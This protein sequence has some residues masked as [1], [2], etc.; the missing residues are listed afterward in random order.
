MSLSLTLEHVSAGYGET[1]VLEDLSLS[2]EAGALV[3]ILGR[4]GVGKT[5][6]FRTLMGHTDLHKGELLLNTSRLAS[7]SAHARSRAGLGWVPQDRQIFPSLTVEENIQIA[8]RPGKWTP[9]KVL[10]LFPQIAARRDNLGAQLSGGEQQMLSLARALVGN[11]SVLLLDEP[12]EGL[13]PTVAETILD[14]IWRLRREDEMTILVVE[15]HVNVALDLAPR[16]IVLDRGRV[17]FDGPSKELID[18]EER[19][20][21]LMGGSVRQH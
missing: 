10:E 6:L 21:S 7:L 18:D 1:I 3:A 17:A 13:A 12:L 20:N 16:S 8:K 5:T 9:Q 4:N 19:L 15:Q 11:P 2:I 14:S